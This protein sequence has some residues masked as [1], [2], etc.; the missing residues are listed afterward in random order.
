LKSLQHKWSA[1]GHKLPRRAQNEKMKLRHALVCVCVRQH[2]HLFLGVFDVAEKWAALRR[3][4]KTSKNIHA[5]YIA[6]NE[7][8][9][10]LRAPRASLTVPL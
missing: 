1:I 2:A 8:N 4:E 3:A 7:C 5:E 6:N 10:H 9:H